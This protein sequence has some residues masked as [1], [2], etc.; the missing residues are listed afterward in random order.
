MAF[1]SSDNQGAAVEDQVLQIK[2]L[3]TIRQF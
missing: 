2:K 3:S 1:N